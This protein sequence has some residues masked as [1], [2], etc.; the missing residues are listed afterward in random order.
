MAARVAETSGSSVFDI[1]VLEDAGDLVAFAAV[2]TCQ[3]G[4][5][6]VTGIVCLVDLNE[7][8]GSPYYF[9]KEMFENE[10]PVAAFCSDRILD[11]LTEPETGMA[12]AWRDRCRTGEPFSDVDDLDPG[13]YPEIAYPVC[14]GSNH[15]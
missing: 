7:E 13:V 2:E 3:V 1:E 9:I 5:K 6:T 11:L 15:I 4:T 8:R 12:A 14:T 10:G